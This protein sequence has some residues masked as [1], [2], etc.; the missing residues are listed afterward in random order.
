M[1]CG[2]KHNIVDEI[3]EE[4]GRF[5]AEHHG[6]ER[7]R[8]R[9]ETSVSHRPANPRRLRFAAQKST[10]LR[11]SRHL[12]DNEQTACMEASKL[13]CSSFS[14]QSLRSWSCKRRTAPIAVAFAA[15]E[16]Q[17]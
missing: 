9:L 17:R 6:R 10:C 4:I 3:R 16:R 1:E 11:G 15:V 8:L 13:H 12:F 14:H 7:A 5:K 2:V